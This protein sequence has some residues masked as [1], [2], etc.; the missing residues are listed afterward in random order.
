M[1]SIVALAVIGV[2]L[3]CARRGEACTTLLVG[4]KAS[5]NGRVIVGHNEDDPGRL[6]VRHGLVPARTYSGGA[7]MICEEYAARPALTGTTPKIFWTEVR[8]EKGMS[9]A[10]CFVNEW[11]VVL[12]SNSCAHSRKDDEPDLTGGGLAYGLRRA[13]AEGARSARD[14]V[15]LACRLLNQWGYR[16]PGRSYAVAD[17]EEAWVLQVSMGKVYCAVRLDDHMA[18]VIPNHFTIQGGDLKD[19]PHFLSPDAISRAQARGWCPRGCG[20][21]AFDFAA[22]YQ[23]PG[24]VRVDGNT[25]RHRHAVA[26]LT[27][28]MPGADEKLPFAVTPNRPLTDRDVRTILQDHY[29]G[30]PDDLTIDFA[31]HSPHYTPRRRICTGG[32]VES[33]VVLPHANPHLTEI[34][35]AQSRPCLSPY[36]TFDLLGELPPQLDPLD[37]PAAALDRHCQS[38]PSQLND[39]A[40]WHKLFE[41]Q[42]LIDLLYSSAHQTVSEWRKKR[43]DELDASAEEA[44]LDR[45]RLADQGD[46]E[47][48][49]RLSSSRAKRD[50]EETDRQMKALLAPFGPAQAS[51]SPHE[52]DKSDP[53]CQLTV[54]FECGT[55]PFESSLRLGQ[56]G[57]APMTWASPLAGSLRQ[58]GPTSWSVA[59]RAREATESA[60]PCA[61]GFWLAGHDVSGQPIAALGRLTVR[62]A[63]PRE[64]FT[65][66][67]SL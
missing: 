56:S 5:A 44:R 1:S 50:A 31:G 36:Q 10:D 32:T 6:V 19:R 25:Y 41:R 28:R 7:R 58:V 2:L 9:S 47:E 17:A 61:G 15:E 21:E 57:S 26:A 13:L 8:D 49:G 3:L 54:S 29:E 46:W 33:W 24:S 22:A 67:C 37:D 66:S 14:G 20:E 59:F 63:Q 16:T 39:G 42:T 38:D 34:Q 4:K 51:F 65:G 40:F 48:A 64:T 11:G 35:I 12:V 23:D 62:P 55:S 30:T 60:A 53:D 27:G 52:V 45:C 18:A 43:Q